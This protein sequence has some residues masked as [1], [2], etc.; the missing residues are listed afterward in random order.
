M[1][2]TVNVRMMLSGEPGNPSAS[3]RIYN[4]CVCVSDLCLK[5]HMPAC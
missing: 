3:V 2:F 5:R 4:L 1:A